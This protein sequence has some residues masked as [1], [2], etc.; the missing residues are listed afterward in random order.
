MYRQG[1][2]TRKPGPIR[3]TKLFLKR[4]FEWWSK[5]KL[6]QKIAV[7]SAPILAFLIITPL[8]TY[9]YYYNDIANVERLLNK[10]NTGVVLLDKNNKVFFSTANAAHRDPVQLSGISDD[11][12]HALVASEDKDFYKHGG[13]SALSIL[14][15]MY[16]NVVARG[17][18]GGGSTITQQLAKNTL[19]TKNQTILRKY[20]ELTIAMAIEQRY[21]KDEI[22]DMYLNSVFFGENSFGIEA[23]AHN[24]FG[25]KPSQLDLAESAMLIGVLPA[26]SAYSPISGDPALAKER[27]TTVL[28]RMV[29]NGYITEDQKAA[30]LKETL[31]YKKQGSG[32]N[33]T[34]PHFTEMILNELYKKYGEEKVT[35]SGFQVKTTLD[36]NMQKAANKS[37]ADNIAYIQSQGGSNASLVAIDPTTGGIRALVGSY[38]YND[39]KF[40]KVN[41]ATTPRQPGSSFKPIYYSDALAKAVITPV[42]VFNDVKITDLGTFSPHNADLSYHG[43]VTTRQALNWSLNIPSVRVMQK[44]GI[45]ESV[46][47]AKNLGITTLSD[48]K[49]YGLSLA[50]GSAEVPL[51]EMTSAYSAF[52]NS[53]EQ[54]AYYS[55]QSIEDKYGHK[56]FTASKDSHRAISEQGAYLI[57]NILSDNQTRSRIFG[58]SLNVVGTD[59]KTKTV[60]VK[61]GTTDE[62]RDAWTIGYTPDVTVG[63]WVGN[64]DNAPM[65]NGGSGM[66]G[67]IWR[68]MMQYAIGTKNPTFLQPSGITKATVCT[69]VGTLTDVFLTGHVPKECKKTTVTKKK[70]KSDD[71]TVTKKKCTVQGKESLSADDPSCAVDMC[72][73]TGL[74]DLAAND[75]NCVDP[76]TTDTD[77]DGVMDDKDK[78]PNTAAGASVD[79][80]GCSSDQT[81]AEQQ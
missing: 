74:E 67:P 63:V 10:N 6:W 57:S 46:Q 32:I 47:A 52:A 14:R 13:F 37:V 79:A 5:L 70:T 7:V 50:L 34:A 9:L 45:D 41:M 73:Y 40:G 71:S 80:V 81:P 18:T 31:H 49:N 55:I 51:V 68:Q 78:C 4:R 26:P 29:K 8:L 43:K 19:L 75:P 44:L 24:Y 12:E 65:Y 11:T 38:N 23:A 20:Q 53:G 62:N 61:T 25:K 17:I 64:N 76:S 69:E 77:N 35:R 27:Q 72:T 15:A 42:T 56:T 28:T 21:S 59:Y 16:T 60:A 66:A 22:L 48:S 1:R 58:S 3:S 36:L 30:A 54:Q 33:N 39:T 2:Y